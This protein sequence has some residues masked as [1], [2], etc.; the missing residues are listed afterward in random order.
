M[1]KGEARQRMLELIQK[2]NQ[3]AHALASIGSRS[4]VPQLARIDRL[5][6]AKAGSI[7]ELLVCA[8][9]MAKGW[10]VY[11]AMDATCSCDLMCVKTGAVIRIEVKT[12]TRERGRALSLHTKIGKFDVLALV[13]G[14]D[15]HYYAYHQ[16][17][18][19]KLPNLSSPL[20][21]IEQSLGC[22]RTS[23]QGGD[24]K[25]EIGVGL[26]GVA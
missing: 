1:S 8:D 13:D 5:L 21:E 10:D 16:L 22:N 6:P 3:E 9:L 14:A 17:G 18:N 24:E 11:R 15:L 4:T 20:S 26:E 7:S 19:L 2:T 12:G 25:H 23:D